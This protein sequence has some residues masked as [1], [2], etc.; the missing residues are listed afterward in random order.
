M[1]FLIVQTKLFIQDLS[2]SILIIVSANWNT[3][4]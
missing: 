1:N 4:A 3:E 2:T